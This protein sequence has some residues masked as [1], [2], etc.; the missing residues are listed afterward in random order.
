MTDFSIKLKYLEIYFSSLEEKKNSNE[1]NTEETHKQ[2]IRNKDSEKN[3][4][5]EVNI[6]NKKNNKINKKKRIYSSLDSN[7]INFNQNDLR[8]RKTFSFS[9]KQLKHDYIGRTTF[10]PNKNN[11]IMQEEKEELFKSMVKELNRDEIINIFEQI[12]ETNITLNET[13]INLIEIEKSIK[14]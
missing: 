14:K 13:D 3:N 10:N 12:K 8:E 1:N 11:D 4:F 2:E 7:D 6:N 5:K 9:D